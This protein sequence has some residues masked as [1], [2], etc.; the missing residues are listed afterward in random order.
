MYTSLSVPYE[1]MELKVRKLKE[2]FYSLTE[3]HASKCTPALIVLRATGDS[4]NLL[5]TY[6][7]ASLPHNQA[8]C[9][10]TS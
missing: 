5:T 7:A 3:K 2:G 9:K 10:Q 8:G 6:A 4:P 1:G